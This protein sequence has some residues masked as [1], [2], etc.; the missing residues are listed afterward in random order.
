MLLDQ[1]LACCI[2]THPQILQMIENE[3]FENL[4]A[5]AFVRGH[6]HQFARELKLPDAYDFAKL[7][8]DKMQGGNE[9]EEE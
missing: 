4:P 9:Q 1:Y 8:V 3:D 6:V 7:Y 5:V 2:G